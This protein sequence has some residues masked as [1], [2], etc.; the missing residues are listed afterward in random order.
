MRVSRK[1]KQASLQKVQQ[2][3]K[4]IEALLRKGTLQEKSAQIRQKLDEFLGGDE[5]FVLVTREGLGVIHTN[6]LR[7]GILFN[8]SV[9]LKAAQT[10]EPLVQIYPRNTGEVLLDAAAPIRV[11]GEIAYSLRLGVVVPAL[12]FAWKLVAASVIPVL[13]VTVGL[14]MTESDWARSVIQVAALAIAVFTGL[15]AY[16]S[17]HQSWRDWTSVMKSISSGNIQAR[18]QTNRR[19]E[20][21]QMSFEIN[22]MALGMHGILSELKNTSLSTKEIS[23]KQDEMVQELLSASEELSASLQQV[24]GGSVEQAGLVNDTETVLK[25]ITALIRKAEHDLK[26]TSVIA[27][28]AEQA[29]QQGIE[30]TNHLQSQMQR[31]EQASHSTETSMLE[32][33][34]QAAGIEQM[35]RDIRE[36][37]EQTNML[38]LNAAIEA[39]RAGAEGRGFAV[40]AEEVRKLANRANEAASHIMELAENI[41]K[42]SHQTVHVVQ[43]ERQEVQHGL[44]LVNEL[45]KIMRVLSEK[46]SSS[47]AHTIRNS[48]VMTEVLH[49]VDMVE[50][51]IEKVKQISHVFSLSAKEASAAG[52]VQ[53]KATE[54]VA[55]QNKRLHEISLQIHQIA[56][57]FE[58]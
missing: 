27:Q 18:T 35:I 6:R 51:K 10:V 46:S 24:Y 34:Q 4:E 28:D 9:G 50:Q 48:E 14:A 42:K 43:E 31:I 29:A 17:F 23:T 44:E 41:I 58:L 12:S 2:T 26:A 54:Q 36:I 38:A 33:Q 15:F 19:D 47:A 52:E 57:R 8:D 49:D 1:L 7:E 16:R 32:L 40:V 13:L 53:V 3:A 55:D 30:K 37:A 22:K 21:G 5:Y 20:L 11:N 56:E 39:A 25:T 45:H